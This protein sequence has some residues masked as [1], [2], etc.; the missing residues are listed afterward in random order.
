VQGGPAN[1]RNLL[2]YAAAL[3]GRMQEWREPATLLRAGLYWPGL[4]QPTLDDLRRHWAAECAVVPIVFYRALLQ[5]GD[6][7][8][9]DALCDAL[10]AAGLNPLP[11]YVTSLKEPVAAELLRDLCARTSPAAV[12]NATAFAL[13]AAGSRAQRNAIR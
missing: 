3:L 8:V 2:L 5:S 4:P 9:I 7:A 6:L 11:V 10:A 1:A 12:L 13:S